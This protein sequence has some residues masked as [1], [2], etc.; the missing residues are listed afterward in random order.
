MTPI[1]KALLLA[2]AMVGIA[3]LAVIDIIPESF[4]QWAPFAL[5]AVF[6]SAW[7][8]SRRY[9]SLAFRRDANGGKPS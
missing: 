2:A 7:I 8:G 3:L 4:A 5:L 6:P 1:H 9:C